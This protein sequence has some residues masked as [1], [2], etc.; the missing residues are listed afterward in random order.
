M[1]EPTNPHHPHAE[2]QNVTVYDSE[3]TAHVMRRV[4]ANDRVLHLGWTRDPKP[5]PK[6]Q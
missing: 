2:L 4:D 3:G 5:A 6:A 1:T